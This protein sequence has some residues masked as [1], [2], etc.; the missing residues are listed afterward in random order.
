[1][2][3]MSD[4][5]KFSASEGLTDD[6]S[7][8]MSPKKETFTEKKEKYVAFGRKI[9]SRTKDI[10]DE[11]V[12]K[13][14][15]AGSKVEREGSAVAER[16]VMPEYTKEQAINRS[17][18]TNSV[19]AHAGAAVRGMLGNPRKSTYKGAADKMIGN[20]SKMMIPQTNIPR[21]ETN[22]MMFGIPQSM[23][24]GSKINTPMNTSVIPKMRINTPMQRQNIYQPINKISSNDALKS[25]FGSRSKLSNTPIS[26]PN[27][28]IAK[29]DQ[30]K[31][32]RM[33]KK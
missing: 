27:I 6:T 31:I 24:T 7:Q 4:L 16:T 1:M 11:S 14:M 23:K 29:I 17:R 18:R 33:F 8:D 15:E 22:K 2:D 26:S 3:T 28:P 20:T 5:N 25:I 10:K 9:Q 21:S 13:I 30:S 12:N 19:N 32:R